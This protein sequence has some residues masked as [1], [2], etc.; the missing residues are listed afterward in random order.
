MKLAS[1]AD[2]RARR[3]A[4]ALRAKRKQIEAQRRALPVVGLF[5]AVGFEQE[6]GTVILQM[7]NNNEEKVLLAVAKL[8][9]DAIENL[10]KNIKDASGI[11]KESIIWTPHGSY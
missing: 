8:D 10:C 1:I 4:R 3:E 11:N 5:R 7:Y 6:P 9:V 2:A